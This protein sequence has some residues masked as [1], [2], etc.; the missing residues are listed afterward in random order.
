[1]DFFAFGCV[2]FAI[3]PHHQVFLRAIGLQN[4]LGL[5]GG[6]D[7]IFGSPSDGFSLSRFDPVDVEVGLGVRVGFLLVDSVVLTV[8]V[9]AHYFL[10]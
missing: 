2:A 1:M 7:P 5:L 9:L 6:R 8:G 10:L 3:I 4:F